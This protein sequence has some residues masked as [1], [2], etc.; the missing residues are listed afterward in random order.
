VHTES[1]KVEYLELPVGVERLTNQPDRWIYG[2][3]IKTKTVDH[4]GREI[5]DEE[6]S[7]TDGWEVNAFFPTPIVIANKLYISMMLGV[8]Y[9]IDTQAAVLDRRAILSVNDV[10]PLGDTWSLS[11][12]SFADGMMYHRSAK[13]LVAIEPQ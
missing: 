12:P 5:A 6:R 11:G 7:R 13:E 9:V 2:R 10:G 8:T 3:S 1:G 4:Q